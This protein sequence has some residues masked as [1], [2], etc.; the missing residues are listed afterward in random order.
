MTL[1]V[2]NKDSFI[3]I[4]ATEVELRVEYKNKSNLPSLT[5]NEKVDEQAK[6]AADQQKHQR[7][8]E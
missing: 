2:F 5:Y 4:S 3:S 6:D 8:L 7:P 1:S